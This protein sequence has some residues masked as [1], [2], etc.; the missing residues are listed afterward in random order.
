[1]EKGL[2][3]WNSAFYLFFRRARLFRF[4]NTEE[5]PEWKERGTGDV[6]ILQHK[7]TKHCR[8]LMRRDKTLKVCANHKGKS[9]TLQLCTKC[10]PLRLKDNDKQVTSGLKSRAECH[11]VAD[12]NPQE[13]QQSYFRLRGWSSF[14][15]F[16]MFFFFFFSHVVQRK[17]P[18]PSNCT[19]H[20]LRLSHQISAHKSITF[21][22]R[23]C[24][25]FGW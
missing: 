6:K 17:T 20:K 1:M 18:P 8:I 16:V 19:A 3:A 24:D 15:K 4:D 25:R 2:Q 9:F 14:M 7:D 12:F 21:L 23:D 11:I 13:I 5:P 22:L 10:R